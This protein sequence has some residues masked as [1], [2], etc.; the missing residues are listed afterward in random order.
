[1]NVKGATDGDSLLFG[2]YEVYCRSRYLLR[3]LIVG[4]EESFEGVPGQGLCLD[5]FG[6]RPYQQEQGGDDSSQSPGRRTQ[7]YADDGRQCSPVANSTGRSLAA[8]A[9]SRVGG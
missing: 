6:K 2:L 5:T 1:L 8:L 7:C 9:T 4:A 3:R